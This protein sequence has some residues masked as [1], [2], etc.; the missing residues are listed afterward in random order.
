MQLE[1]VEGPDAGRTIPLER[2]TTLGREGDV[3][4]ADAQV[5]RRHARV[6]PTGGGVVVEDLDSANGTFVNGQQLTGS[7]TLLVGD[8]LQL[9]VTVMKLGGVGAQ[10]QVRQVPVALARPETRPTYTDPVAAP[11]ATRPIV[12]ELDRLRDANTK[13]QTRV[14]PIAI[15]AVA[16][17]AV[18][19][20][21][22][23]R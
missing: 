6:T 10:S 22:G 5:S 4:V 16:A 15:A 7:V 17:L 13:A 19:L 11:P 1:I 12:P 18:I 20:L 9:G 3:T 2:A 21:L 14:A 8:E 23:L